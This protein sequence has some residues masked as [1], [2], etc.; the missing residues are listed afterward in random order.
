MPTE[1]TP[2]E[3][4]KAASLQQDA[5]SPGCCWTGREEPDVP[6]LA[7]RWQGRLRSLITFLLLLT[8]KPAR[9]Y[10]QGAGLLFPAPNPV[11]VPP[12]GSRDADS[13]AAHMHIGRKKLLGEHSKFN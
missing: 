8:A 3:D 11:T 1:E 2:K 13:G 5:E 7:E 9:R 6:Q 12:H 4:D 10:P